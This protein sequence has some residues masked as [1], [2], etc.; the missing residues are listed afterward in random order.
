MNTYF[1]YIE[2]SVWLAVDMFKLIGY[3]VIT[4][5]VLGLVNDYQHF[6]VDFR[7]FLFIFM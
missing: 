3:R 5:I 6:S 1:I 4:R 7:F 2:F